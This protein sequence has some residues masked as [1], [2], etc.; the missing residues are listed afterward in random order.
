MIFPT[1]VFRL[2]RNSLAE[3]GLVETIAE[4]RELLMPVLHAAKN[5]IAFAKMWKPGAGWMET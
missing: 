2:K 1:A 4:L 5:Q 3:T